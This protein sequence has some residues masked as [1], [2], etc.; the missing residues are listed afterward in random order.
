MTFHQNW[1]LSRPHCVQPWIW[2]LS[3]PLQWLFQQNV[4]NWLLSRPLC[5]MSNLI[6]FKT[7]CSNIYG[8]TSQ[9]DSFQDPYVLHRNWLLSR[10]QPFLDTSQLISTP[11][12]VNCLNCNPIQSFQVPQIGFIQCF[13]L[14]GRLP[15]K[16]P[17][18]TT[19]RN[20][21]QNPLQSEFWRFLWKQGERD[22]T[23]N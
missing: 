20:F 19:F 11:P 22:I 6:P 3:R 4:R 2:L 14:H 1:L 5:F 13:N 17:W 16:S 18:E 10:P 7:L 12:A 21:H 23:C 9:I 15:A 8:K